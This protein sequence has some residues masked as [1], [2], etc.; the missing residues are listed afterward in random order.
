MNQNFLK[1]AA[2]IMCISLALI[3]C[4]GGTKTEETTTTD[5]TS[6]TVQ[7]NPPQTSMQGDAMDAVTVAPNLY[8]V[9]GDS[10]GIRILEATYK[11]GDSSAM[12]TQPDNAVYVIQGGSVTSFGK[13]GKQMV[14]EVKTG[15]TSIRAASEAHVTKNTGNTTIKT[16]IVQVNRP[17]ETISKDASTDPIK[18]APEEYK[19]KNDSLGIRILQI[20]YKPGQS[21][22][23]HAHPDG[24][25]YVIEGGTTEFTG[26]DGKKQTTTLKPG[27]AM[28][29][30]ADVHSVKNVGKTTTKAILVEVYRKNP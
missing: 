3:A 4:N 7:T 25:L 5:T 19:V 14:S 12:H 6:N 24:V 13:D 11:P 27:M 21:S 9:V 30:P 17:M 16:M 15:S 23:M 10:L 29:A 18:I 1:P 26:K 2:F 8:K 28:I 22:A 20:V